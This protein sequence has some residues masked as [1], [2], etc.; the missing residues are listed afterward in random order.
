MDMELAQ[1]LLNL[2][3]LF[4]VQVHR[5][6]MIDRAGVEVL[7]RLPVD[8]LVHMLFCRCLL[9]LGLLFFDRL[10]KIFFGC[11]F[12]VLLGKLFLLLLLRLLGL[13]L[14]HFGFLLFFG[15]RLWIFYRLGLAS[16]LI[17]ARQIDLEGLFARFAFSLRWL[18]VIL[19][20]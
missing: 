1:H 19:W 11:V 17:T 4:A 2:G 20:R 13:D 9:S 18:V 7:H 3:H 16:V 15:D 14:L 10:G 6:Q 5:D 12:L 8:W